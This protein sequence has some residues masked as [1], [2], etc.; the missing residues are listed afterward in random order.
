MLFRSKKYPEALREAWAS[1]STYDGTDG[2]CTI[3]VL[4][5]VAWIWDAAGAADSAIFYF[6]KYLDTPYNSRS[7]L[8]NIDRPRILERLGQLYEAKG[9]AVKAAKYYREFIALWEHADAALQPKVAD[10]KRRLSRLADV[11]R[12]P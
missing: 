2:S 8:E 6:Q 1:D 11:E 5:D 12:K 7:G 9:D 3:C 10:A 4:D